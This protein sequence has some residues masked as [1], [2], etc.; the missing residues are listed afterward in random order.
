MH[1]AVDTLPLLETLAGAER[2]TE[3]LLRNL[4][5]LDK[6]NR[7]TVYVSKANRKRFEITQGN[8][9]SIVSKV[10]IRFRL[11]RIL[12][13]Q[14]FVPVSLRRQQVDLFY[15]A[16]NVSP[17]MVHCP[18]VVSVH[19]LHWFHLSHLFP[20]AKLQYLRM[21][22]GS[23]VRRA[24]LVTTL[25]E[26]SAQ[27][28]HRFFGVRREKIHV[29]PAAVSSVFAH[30]SCEKRRQLVSHRYGITRAFILHVGETL[31]R[32]NLVRLV[33]A[34]A[35]LSRQRLLKHGLVFVG[36]KGDG[37]DDIANAIR[38]L[39]LT[40]D[41]LLMGP[42]SSDEDLSAFYGAADLVVYPSLYEGF[43][44]PIIEAFACG[45]PVVTSNV[46]SLPEVAGEAAILVDP[47]DTKAMAEAIWQALSD[48][49]LRR[50]LVERGFRRAKDYS[51]ER[52]AQ[53]LRQTFSQAANT[54]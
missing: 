39:D 19:D 53:L 7:Y 23:S 40:N 52:S 54:G 31:K 18:V 48:K 44:I 45:T 5:C 49:Q 2:F 27:D 20:T 3:N 21:A 30:G 26:S 35:L 6:G 28:I 43:G 50:E 41:V 46:S 38:R 32:K 8:F 16:C 29:I 22:I 12:W 15:S 25:S 36:R 47:T 4:A 51:W 37:Y 9:R 17:R 14:L 42:V 24:T 1:I 10:P 11:L 33:E 13:Q 34:Y